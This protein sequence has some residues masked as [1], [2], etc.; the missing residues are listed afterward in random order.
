MQSVVTAI[1]VVTVSSILIKAGAVASSA[2]AA[3]VAHLTDYNI[4]FFC[5]RGG[6]DYIQ[7]STSM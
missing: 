4:I 5:S 1:G 6:L 3:N 2:A 7:L